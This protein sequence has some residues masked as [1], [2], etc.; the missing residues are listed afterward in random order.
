MSDIEGQVAVL[1]N[2]SVKW[3][4]E[5]LIFADFSRL[6]EQ[7]CD[8]RK[9]FD[10]IGAIGLAWSVESPQQKATSRFKQSPRPSAS[11][12]T[13][14]DSQPEI[15]P[16]TSGPIN[17]PPNSFKGEIG[18]DRSELKT[19]IKRLRQSADDVEHLHLIRIRDILREKYGFPA[20]VP[21]WFAPVE[22][23]LALKK[24]G[25]RPT[26]L[27]W[28]TSYLNWASYRARGALVAGFVSWHAQRR[29][30]VGMFIHQG[31]PSTLSMLQR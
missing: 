21:G 24:V 9:L 19:V 23:D 17:L 7:N 26:P 14:S 5:K 12:G 13:P 31:S 30:L 28:G 11:Q 8:P 22:D 3:L 27:T 1:G 16:S 6:V 29:K 18:F 2:Q 25:T 10:A 15:E 4:K 20:E